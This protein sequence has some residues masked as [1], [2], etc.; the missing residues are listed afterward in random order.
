MCLRSAELD[1]DRRRF[2]AADAER[3]EAALLA[4]PAERVDERRQDACTRRADR[5]AERA[6]A[7][8]YAL[9]TLE[10]LGVEAADAPFVMRNAMRQVS[11]WSFLTF[12]RRHA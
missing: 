1:G 10:T 5:V 9:P 7:A 11:R 2:S 8:R 6:R 3:R 4:V 12:T